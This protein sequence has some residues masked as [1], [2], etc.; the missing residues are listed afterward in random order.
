MN[1]GYMTLTTSYLARTEVGDNRP[2]VLYNGSIIYI[3]FFNTNCRTVYQVGMS[4]KA[5]SHHANL[6]ARTFYVSRDR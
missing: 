6:N 3:F 2:R 4:G 1:P 5:S